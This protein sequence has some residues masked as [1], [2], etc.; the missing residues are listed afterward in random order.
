MPSGK[1]P[2][3]APAK[4]TPSASKPAPKA[5]TSNTTIVKPTEKK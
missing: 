1:A 5:N 4:A 3:A 2:V